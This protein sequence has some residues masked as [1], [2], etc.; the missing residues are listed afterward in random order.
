MDVS[1][2]SRA[3]DGDVVFWVRT[4]FPTEKRLP[5]VAS[6]TQ[7]IVSGCESPSSYIVNAMITYDASGQMRNVSN[8]VTKH[9]LTEQSN[10]QRVIRFACHLK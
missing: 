1:A 8:D 2:V 10:L 9:P 6:A 7:H 5:N 4:T 3:A